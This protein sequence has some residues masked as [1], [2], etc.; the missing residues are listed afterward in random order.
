[1]AKKSDKK[2]IMLSIHPKYVN[3]IMDGSKKVE[4]RRNGV[5]E[6]ISNIVVY[7]T[8]PMKQIIGYCEISECVVSTPDKLWEKYNAVGGI[9][10]RDFSLYYKGYETGKCYIIKKAVR[11]NKSVS[12]NDFSSI[13]TPPQSFIYV[14][15]V[16]FEQL[17]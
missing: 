7:A 9:K 13:K 5:P 12:F 6:D 1:M 16:E 15:N 11:F 8:S 14:N 3:A 4:F 17:L 10:R 2:V